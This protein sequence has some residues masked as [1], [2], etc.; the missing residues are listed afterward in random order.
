MKYVV[1][2]TSRR[3]F[4]SP[5]RW[6]VA[7]IILI[8]V[9]TG[10]D[11]IDPDASHRGHAQDEF[12][13]V[14]GDSATASV[15]PLPPGTSPG[16][17][18]PVSQENGSLYQVCWPEVWNGE[19]VVYAHGYVPPFEDLSI[20]PEA[21][22][23]ADLVLPVGFAF[24]TT[25][26]PD[27]GLVVKEGVS[28]LN[29]LVAYVTREYAAA[30]RVYLTGASEGGLIT[31]LAAEQHPD[32]F[33]GGLATCGP[34]GSFREQTN[35]FGDARVVFDYFFP[36]VLPRWTADDPRIPEAV[37][38]NWET[39]YAPR[40]RRALRQRPAATRRFLRVT[41][42]PVDRDDADAVVQAVID[43]LAYNVFATNDAMDTLGGQP[44]DNADRR[45]TGA[46][47]R[48]N[49]E[50]ER[51]EADPSAVEEMETFYR[52]SG[53]LSIPLVTMHTTGDAIVPIWQQTLYRSKVA[54]GESEA[55]HSG[56]PIF[57]Y[58]HCEFRDSELLAG[59]ALLVSRVRDF[60][61]SDAAFA[62][63]T[64]AE[65]RNFKQLTRQY[66]VR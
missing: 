1:Q 63:S 56:L 27:N 57:R 17:E 3:A 38:E 29:A 43:V 30:E 21:E 35:W 33:D 24:A 26:Y 61:L 14:G 7:I 44:Y 22:A 9:L 34:Y 37:I 40:V 51:F 31:A 59:F 32:V 15:R 66:G 20:P 55:L 58:G 46:G 54:E 11:A 42:L 39:T 36:D 50:I 53:A 5:V 12:G 62:L 60:P 65:Q 49:R 64:R 41:G 52:T 19:L 18:A 28:D 47:L 13:A 6:G 8:L 25:S 45:Y 2:R 4:E 23:L 48:L 16:C 10:C